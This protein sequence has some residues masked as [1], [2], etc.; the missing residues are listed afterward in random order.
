MIVDPTGSNSETGGLH[1]HTSVKNAQTDSKEHK[2]GAGH[3]KGRSRSPKAKP[4]PATARSDSADLAANGWTRVGKKKEKQARKGVAK[5]TNQP[6]SFMFNVQELV[7]MG[8]ISIS[9][10]LHLESILN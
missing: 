5:V 9:V 1:G 8:T 3:A 2:N 7:K 6:P 10:S 4:K